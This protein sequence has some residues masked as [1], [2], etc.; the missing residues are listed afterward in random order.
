MHPQTLQDAVTNTRDFESAK[1]EANHNYL[2][3]LITP[4]NATSN[5]SEANQKPPTNNI[6]PATIIENK[7][8]TAIFPFEFEEPVEMPLFSGAALES[9]LITVMYT[10]AKVNGQHI[11]LILDSGSAEGQ[12]ELENGI[13]SHA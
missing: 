2:S 9:K 7:L 4:E 13:I 1:L 6:L 5:K 10:D 3:L 12:N 8:L 11:K